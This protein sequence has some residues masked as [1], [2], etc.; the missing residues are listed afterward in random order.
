MRSYWMSRE[1]RCPKKGK[2]P[3]WPFKNGELSWGWPLNSWSKRIGRRHSSRWIGNGL[4]AT[5]GPQKFAI[6]GHPRGPLHFWWGNLWFWGRPIFEEHQFLG[7]VSILTSNW[8][9]EV[10]FGFKSRLVSSSPFEIFLAKV[11]SWPAGRLLGSEETT[12]TEFDHSLVIIYSLS[13][14]RF[15]IAA[16]M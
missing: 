10:R 9:G 15:C 8:L 16:W 5:N 13:L 2:T 12:R 11:D 4:W 3:K 14:D 7:V 1:R 6:F